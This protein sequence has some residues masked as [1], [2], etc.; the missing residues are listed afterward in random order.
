MKNLEKKFFNGRDAFQSLRP[1]RKKLPNYIN[2]YKYI[3]IIHFSTGRGK[4]TI[5][6]MC[7]QIEH[8]IENSEPQSV[9]SKNIFKP[10]IIILKM[11][12]KCDA[13]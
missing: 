8:I 1:V 10:E 6:M 12:N 7:E 11:F 5:K 13:E 2:I 4:W 3:N 9:F